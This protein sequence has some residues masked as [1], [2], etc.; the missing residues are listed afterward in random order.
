MEVEGIAELP[1][2]ANPLSVQLVLKA[3]ASSFNGYRD[4]L[5]S[6]KEQLEDWASKDEYHYLLLTI[7][8]DAQNQEHAIR[9]AAI[10]QLKNGIDRRWRKG[11]SNPIGDQEK[12]QI[13]EL[14][15]F[16]GP[17]EMD[18]QI[19][20]MLAVVAAKIARFD[21]PARW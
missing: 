15:L 21:F 4:G 19:A 5:L 2:S 6:S 16:A 18:S 10:I 11:A 7:V 9:L 13:E 20:K 12:K 1:A 8:A 3:L 17:N 14:L